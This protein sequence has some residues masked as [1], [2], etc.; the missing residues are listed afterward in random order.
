MQKA[1]IVDTIGYAQWVVWSTSTRWPLPSDISLQGFHH[2][3]SDLAS[4]HV[5]GVAHCA[6][7]LLICLYSTTHGCIEIK[8]IGL[9]SL[10]TLHVSTKCYA[11][12]NR[13]KND[14]MPTNQQSQPWVWQEICTLCYFSETQQGKKHALYG[15][16]GLLVMSNVQKDLFLWVY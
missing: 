1:H 13:G 12:C 9:T 7:S 2:K 4:I 5:Y 11:N 8:A 6:F 14:I 10:N 3:S 16:H 15:T